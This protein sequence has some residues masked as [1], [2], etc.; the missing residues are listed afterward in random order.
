M[1]NPIIRYLVKLKCIFI[2]FI[3][4][5]NMDKVTQ[6][7]ILSSWVSSCCSSWVNHFAFKGYPATL[8]KILDFLQSWGIK[9][10]MHKL[11]YLHFFES[12][13]TYLT[14]LDLKWPTLYFHKCN[15][16][17]GIVKIKWIIRYYWCQQTPISMRCQH[18]FCHVIFVMSYDELLN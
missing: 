3:I 13:R 5:Q 6:R 10:N 1:L 12:G 18:N 16:S 2:N 15:L 14:L 17:K 8:K 4:L 9:E 11:S 7:L